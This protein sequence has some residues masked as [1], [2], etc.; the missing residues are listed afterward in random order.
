MLTYNC[1]NIM[2]KILN[3]LIAIRSELIEVKEEINQIKLEIKWKQDV[4]R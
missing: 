2:D 1:D 3:E 4:S